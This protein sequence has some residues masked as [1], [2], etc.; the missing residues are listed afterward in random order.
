M[1][2][3]EKKEDSEKSKDEKEE[4]YEQE[5]Q[6]L[7]N[8][9]KFAKESLENR[10][11]QYLDSVPSVKEQYKT[12]EFE[13]RFGKFAKNGRNISKIDYDN[14][15]K[16]IMSAG[17]ISK[18]KDGLQILRIYS[19]FQDPKTGQ[20][21][22]SNIRAEVVGT[23]LISEYCST[24]SLEKLL[25]V[26]STQTNKLKFTQ[27]TSTL[28]KDGKFQKPIDF[29]DMGFRVDFKYEQDY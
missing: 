16:Q 7:K 3:S 6:Q 11:K 12:K 18:N 1:S 10:L 26:P 27:K 17:F 29:P 15:I 9:M 5:R 8:A 14:V 13:I 28:D 25:L 21:K 22:M 24:N 20:T 19:Q 4:E 23:D 2:T